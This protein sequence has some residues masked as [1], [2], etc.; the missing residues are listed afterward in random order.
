MLPEIDRVEPEGARERIREVF[1][2]RI[3]R[4]KGLDEIVALAGRP[5]LPT[6]KA[7]LQLVEAFPRQAPDFGEFLLVDKMPLWGNAVWERLEYRRPEEERG[8][9]P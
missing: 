2:Q 8:V 1:L 3:V 9:L 6:P 7:V 4:G 5:P